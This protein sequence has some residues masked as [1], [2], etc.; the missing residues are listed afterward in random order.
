[1]LAYCQNAQVINIYKKTCIWYDMQVAIIVFFVIFLTAAI[2]N[3]Y[4]VIER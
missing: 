4:T 2:T 3:V 1:M